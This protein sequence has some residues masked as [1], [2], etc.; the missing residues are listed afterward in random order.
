[1]LTDASI[2]EDDRMEWGGVQR[3][4][5]LKFCLVERQILCYY[6][7]VIVFLQYCF[8]VVIVPHCSMLFT[9]SRR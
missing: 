9:H 4:K 8:S 3:V 7:I 5:A 2:F 6:S 1:M